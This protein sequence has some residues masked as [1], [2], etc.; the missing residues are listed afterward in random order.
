[1]LM[2][3]LIDAF[4]IQAMFAGFAC[5]QILNVVIV[6][7]Y[8]P[9]PEKKPANVSDIPASESGCK[10]YGKLWTFSAGLFFA[11]LMVY[12]ICMCLIENFLFIY[13]VQE[14][15]NV[16]NVL[17]GASIAVMCAFEI[18]VFAYLGPWLE[19][20]PEGSEVAF[21]AILFACQLITALRCWLYAIMPRDMA[22]LVL[23]VGSL[24]GISFAAMWVVSMEYAKRMSTANN[25]ATM[26]SLTG[27]IYYFLSAAI[28]SLMWGTLVVVPE[29]GG[30]GFRSSFL[31]DAGAMLVWSV[32]W[33]G[34]VCLCTKAK[35]SDVQEDLVSTNTCL[36]N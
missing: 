7:R 9:E 21:T 34:L 30:I 11:N 20:Q 23:A 6:V 15:D 31:A 29:N 27:G 28:G 13:L 25:L 2:G 4:G 16:P 5:I 18:P 35:R 22:W 19:K 32:I 3:Q 8:M 17:L 14:F 10:K 12:G 36:G 24:H 1:M 26:T 33:L